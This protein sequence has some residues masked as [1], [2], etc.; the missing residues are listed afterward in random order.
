MICF[1]PSRRA[2]S[3]MIRAA[4]LLLF[5]LGAAPAQDGRF[6]DGLLW[7]L[8][9]PDGG[10]PSYL[11]GTMHVSD[12]RVLAIPDAVERAMAASDVAVFELIEGAGM[13]SP[14][15]GSALYEDG[16]NLE[17]VAGPELWQEVKDLASA[18]GMI[19]SLTRR[20]EPWVLVMIFSSP[21][22][23]MRAVMSG[24]EVLDFRLQTMAQQR[25]MELVALETIEEQIA[26]F[27]GLAEEDQLALLRSMVENKSEQ[28]EAFHAMIDL[29]LARNLSG[30]LAVAEDAGSADEAALVDRFMTRLKTDR[31]RIMFERLQPLLQRGG[32]LFIAVGVLHLAGAGGLLDRFVEAGWT[33]TRQD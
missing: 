20:F 15:T 24:A 16:R 6:D 14:L 28:D 3:T 29:Y 13:G 21:V 7:R 22:E 5:W 2:V 18:Y 23:E 12:P 17:Q 31:D 32:G 8:D 9:P 4:A 19:P 33:V 1:Q 11:L 25:G 26:A 27:E 10:R 30:L